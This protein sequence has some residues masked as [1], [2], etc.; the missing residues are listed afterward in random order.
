M[1]IGQ[2]PVSSISYWFKAERGRDVKILQSPLHYRGELLVDL[3]GFFYSAK[4]E[5]SSDIPPLL[6]VAQLLH[7]SADPEQ[8]TS[9]C[10]IYYNVSHIIGKIIQK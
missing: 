3:I 1:L 9:N 5:L 6:P 10:L 4:A 2:E 8:I 7:S